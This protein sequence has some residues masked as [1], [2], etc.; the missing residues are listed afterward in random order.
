MVVVVTDDGTGQRTRVVAQ[1]TRVVASL[2]VLAV[3][4]PEP[5][6]GGCE[7]FEKDN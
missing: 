4:S 5:S 2:E 1:R 3:Q 6:R 7:V